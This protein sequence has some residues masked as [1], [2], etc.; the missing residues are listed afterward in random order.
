MHFSHPPRAEIENMN[1]KANE[2]P[3]SPFSMH[4]C[5]EGNFVLGGKLT[6]QAD[7]NESGRLIAKR[8]THT[9]YCKD[10]LLDTHI[11]FGLMFISCIDHR[12]LLNYLK[13]YY[14]FRL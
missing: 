10:T 3:S 11:I 1:F 5:P 9:A 6:S 8:R 7:L 4:F 12:N 2:W 13:G 14:L